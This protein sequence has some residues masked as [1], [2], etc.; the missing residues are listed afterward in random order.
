LLRIYTYLHIIQFNTQKYL[1]DTILRNFVKI[2]IQISVERMNETF[3]RLLRVIRGR[4]TRKS[5]L[6]RL[7]GMRVSRYC[8]L[9]KFLMWIYDNEWL[10]ENYCPVAIRFIT[11]QRFLIFKIF[12]PLP[13]AYLSYLP[14]FFHKK[15]NYIDIFL[16]YTFKI[17]LQE[18]SHIWLRNVIILMWHIFILSYCNIIFIRREKSLLYEFPIKIYYWWKISMFFS[19]SI[20]SF[21]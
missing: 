18:Y 11:G 7:I 1:K 15:I 21:Q 4:R 2:I 12:L 17:K 3:D 5:K 16:S 6:S 9:T 19:F 20:K 14:L 8:L 10:I 13:H